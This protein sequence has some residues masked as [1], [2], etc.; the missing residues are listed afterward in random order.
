MEF[1]LSDEQRALRDEARRYLEREAPVSYARAMMDEPLH[2]RPGIWRATADLGWL[3]L[4][5]PEDAGGV[6]EGFSALAILLSEMG[7]VVFPGPY[8]STVL[9]GQAVMV[10]GT[11]EQRKELL[12]PLCAGDLIATLALDDRDGAA[13]RARR[14]GDEW[15]LEGRQAFVVDAESA[16]ALVVAAHAP[17]GPSLFACS[18]DGVS[19]TPLDVIDRTRS[20]S[21]VEFADAPARRMDG[22][23]PAI[24]RVLDR[25]SV[26]VAAEMLGCAE[27]ALELAV[28]YAKVRMQFGRPIGSFQAVKH[29]A[30]SMH[31][32]VE[33]ARNA[34]WYAAWSIERDTQDASLAASTAKAVAGDAA[35]RVTAGAI[36]I[37]GGIG[38]TWEHDAHLYFK[39]VKLGEALFGDATFHRERAAALLAARYA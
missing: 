26:A 11:P 2:H 35:R 24:A 9:A 33:S 22:G 34:V 1:D 18:R 39:R 32:D 30:A 14:G 19:T 15:L 27:R 37:H 20:V 21:S 4:P 23:A 3:G 29:R 12:T 36:Q 6:G 7:R 38:F 10:A 31:V 5:L 28:D 16:Q 8:L 17:D 13:V 25:A